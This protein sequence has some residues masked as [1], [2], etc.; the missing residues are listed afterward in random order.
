MGGKFAKTKVAKVTM[1]LK[2]ANAQGLWLIDS[3]H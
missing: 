2:K 1:K 3:I